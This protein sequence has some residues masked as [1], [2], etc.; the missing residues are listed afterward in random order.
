MTDTDTVWSAVGELPP[1]WELINLR[2]VARL[3]SGHTPSRQHSE[4]WVPEDCTI[5]WFSLADVWQ[6]REQRQKYLGE[7]EQKVSEL[8]LKNSAARL[9]PSGTVV[10]SRT[11]SV[12]YAGIMPQ[13]MATTQ[14]FANWVPGPSLHADFLFYV[15]IA[16]MPEFERL[17]MGST[18]QTIYMPD[19]KSLSIPLPP[20]SVQEA[21][22]TFL[23]RKTAGIDALIEK[24]QKL[25]CLLAEKRSALI[26]QAVIKGLDPG[27]PMKDSGIHWIGEIPAH[28]ETRRIATVS[29]KITNGYVGPTRGL[30]VEEGVPYLQ[31][32]HVKDNCIRFRPTYFVPE[33]WSGLRRKS[34]LHEGDVVVVQTGDIG[35]VAAVPPEWE[36]ANCHALIVISTFREGM[37]GRFLAWLLNS[38]FGFASLKSIQTGALHPHLNCGLVRELR[39]PC[40]PVWEQDRIVERIDNLAEAQRRT[41]RVTQEQIARLHEYRQALI[42]AAVT[43]QLD[44]PSTAATLTAAASATRTP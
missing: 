16:M 12:G 34:I 24:K 10:L 40:P 22:A 4:Y 5:P 36:G 30:F 35:Q 1:A 20:R 38:P 11:A 7:T 39:L 41:Q 44:I 31:S 21:I 33:E 17:R 6:L 18:H 25:L 2:R 28:W 13:S 9:L 37:R 19:I 42:T 32:L 26:N 8:G 15:F 3:E 43:G 29:S 14:D 23:D 27:V